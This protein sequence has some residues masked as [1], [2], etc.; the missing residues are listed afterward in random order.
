[1]NKALPLRAR[2]SKLEKAVGEEASWEALES[3]RTLLIA[4]SILDQSLITD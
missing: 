3:R 2:R 4:V 1:M